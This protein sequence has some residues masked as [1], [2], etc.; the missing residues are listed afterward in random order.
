MSES[1]SSH[2]KRGSRTLVKRKA[3]PDEPAY[4]IEQADG[5]HV[6]KSHSELKRAD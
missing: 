6:L 3:S 1:F 5:D 2:V 4:L